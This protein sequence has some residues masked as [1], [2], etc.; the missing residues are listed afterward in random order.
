MRH[1]NPLLETSCPWCQCQDENVEHLLFHCV[2]FEEVRKKW[3]PKGL[4][5]FSKLPACLRSFALPPGVL[6][7]LGGPTFRIE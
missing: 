4:P 6:L 7:R 1:L 5:D 3:W 2:K